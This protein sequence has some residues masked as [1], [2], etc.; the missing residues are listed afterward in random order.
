MSEQ[1]H[2]QEQQH[3]SGFHWREGWYFQRQPDGGVAISQAELKI[4][5]SVPVAEWAS[6]VASMTAAGENAET[7]KAALDAQT[8]P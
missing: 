7:F 1:E 6:I 8:S 3:Q 5:L 2:S 4:A